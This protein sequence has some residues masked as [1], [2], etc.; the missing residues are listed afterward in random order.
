MEYICDT[1]AAQ[2]KGPLLRWNSSKEVFERLLEV[3]GAFGRG[4]T[5]AN[6]AA[7]N[8]TREW[9]A[10]TRFPKAPLAAIHFKIRAVQHRSRLDDRCWF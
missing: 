10:S 1:G 8:R 9:P 4:W 5:S 3:S 7:G 2:W 6:D